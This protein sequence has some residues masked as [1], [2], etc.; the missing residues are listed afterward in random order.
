M[1][2]IAIASVAVVAF[3]VVVGFSYVLLTAE[4]PQPQATVKEVPYE[5]FAQ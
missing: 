5:S 1:K 4:A 3:L 2:K